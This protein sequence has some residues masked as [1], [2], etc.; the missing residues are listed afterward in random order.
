MHSG[1]AAREINILQRLSHTNIVRYYD[2]HMPFHRHATPWLV[3]KFCNIGTL[4]SLM[5]KYHL[6]GKLVPELFVWQIFESLAKA[7]RYCHDG[8]E[9]KPRRIE[10]E[11]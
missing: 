3:T 6:G 2:N 9:N 5:E 8:P 4:K 1:Y 7:V 10:E 11:Q